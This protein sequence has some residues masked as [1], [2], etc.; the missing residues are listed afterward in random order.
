M[1]LLLDTFCGCV[2]QQEADP[3]AY[4]IE[5]PGFHLLAPNDQVLG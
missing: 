2:N 3:S 4:G 5:Q 1:S